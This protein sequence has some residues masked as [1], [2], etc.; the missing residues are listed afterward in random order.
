M[1]L[2]FNTQ[3]EPN[4][5]EPVTLADGL[6]RITAPNASV[7]TFKGTNTYL[8][9]TEDLAIVDPG[10]DVPEHQD[11]VLAAI[12]GRPVRAILLTHTHRDHT[13]LCA[14]LQAACKAPI[15]AQG[16]H[17]PYRDLSSQEWALFARSADV[18]LI[19]D[20]TLTDGHI[21]SGADWD[22]EIITTPGHTGNH[23][24]FGLVG[25]P[26]LISG[27]HVM[28]WSTT[29]I[30]PPD[31]SMADYLASLDVLLARDESHYLPGHGAAIPNAKSYVKGLKTHRIM[32]ESA[33]EEQVLKG[34]ET[35]SEIVD[36]LYATTPDRLKGA[37]AMTV[38]AH[39]EALVMAG[40]VIC[41]AAIP[42]LDARYRCSNH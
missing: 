34:I 36:R 3:F 30:A 24:C 8:I 20:Q 27:D 33:I 26:Y 40:K 19:P 12:D 18:D 15:L 28:G 25:S 4:Y 32:R 39:L 7:Y 23:A 22:L 35:I 41:S 31:G 6:A 21:L 16:P 9:G 42:S 13:P 5:G 10:P 1:G 37:A 17:R 11:A 2:R 14:A 38:L 29:V